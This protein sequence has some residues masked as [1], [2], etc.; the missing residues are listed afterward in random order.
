MKANY[1]KQ[2]AEA[3]AEVKL[4]KMRED[5]ILYGFYKG[6]VAANKTILQEFAE[7]MKATR[8]YEELRAVCDEM[9]NWLE[10]RSEEQETE[11]KE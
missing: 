1:E 4:K 9:L 2:L 11:G 3:K 6:A 5:M 10:S 8:T 7:R